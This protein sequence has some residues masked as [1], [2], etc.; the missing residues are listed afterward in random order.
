MSWGGRAAADIHSA[1]AEDLPVRYTGAG[2]T[3]AA[4]AAIK[5][6]VPGEPFQ[7]AGKTLRTIS[8]EVRQ[9]DLPQD[10]RKGNTIVEDDGAG[11]AWRVNEVRRRDDNEAWELIVEVGP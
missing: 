4:I 6:D 9:A 2:L 1:F 11:A 3:A 8:F 5:S 10:P 7:G